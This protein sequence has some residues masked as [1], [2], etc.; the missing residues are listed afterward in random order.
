[1]QIWNVE[2]HLEVTADLECSILINRFVTR[3]LT[4]RKQVK[5]ANKMVSVETN[6]VADFDDVNFVNEASFKSQWFGNLVNENP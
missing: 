4:F 1:M 5:L 2:G 3:P 6:D